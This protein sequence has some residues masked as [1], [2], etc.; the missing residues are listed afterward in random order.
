M[1]TALAPL[2]PAQDADACDRVERDLFTDAPAFERVHGTGTGVSVSGAVS[3]GLARLA[4]AGAKR[5]LV[6][7]SSK[8]GEDIV[9]AR[10]GH[11]P[12]SGGARAGGLVR[13]VI[14]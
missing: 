9:R 4:R 8:E 10:R 6:I 11:G 2:P 12:A 14:A 3:R 13:P 5:L 1:Y 7:V